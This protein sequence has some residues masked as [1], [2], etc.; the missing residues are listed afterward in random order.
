MTF[1]YGIRSIHE[2]HDGKLTVSH[3]PDIEMEHRSL[4][5]ERTTGMSLASQDRR[6]DVAYRF[7]PSIVEPGIADR[8]QKFEAQYR[9]QSRINKFWMATISDAVVEPRLLSVL[10]NGFFVREC[11]RP[12]TDLPKLFPGMRGED[13]KRLVGSPREVFT[14]CVG[15]VPTS[16]VDEA[17][18]LGSGVYNNYYNWTIRYAPRVRIFKSF[19]RRVK[20]LSPRFKNEYVRGTLQLHGVG[21]KRVVPVREPILVRTLHI[22][23]P[24]AIGR[25][26]LSP[27]L[28]AGLAD[29]PVPTDPPGAATRLYIPR[30]NVKSRRVVNEAEVS[31]ALSKLG[32]TIFDSAQHSVAAQAGAFHAAE[33]IVGAHG[34]GF[35]N[36][37]YARP[38]TTVVEIIPEGYDQG[39]TSYRSLAD[40]FGLRYVPLFAREVLPNR[41]RCN[42]DIAIDVAELVRTVLDLP[43][44]ASD[45]PNAVLTGAGEAAVA[46]N[47]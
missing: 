18:L 43:Q 20:L 37:V 5:P 46:G 16:T 3:L 23:S 47:A 10:A 13:V 25:H 44:G 17:F 30:A 39:V 12:L 22:C 7:G 36:M 45:G 21:Q 2:L 29:P 8:W 19:R 14:S 40:H 4:F 35:A 34:A 1:Q 31:G 42:S 26:E 6:Q 9:A 32:F 38:G 15:L 28:I 27:Q 11:M 33:I 41:N 24:S